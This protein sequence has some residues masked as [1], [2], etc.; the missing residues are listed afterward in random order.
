MNRMLDVPL[1]RIAALELFRSL[2]VDALSEVQAAMHVERVAKDAIICV[3]GDT[4][5]RA[6]ALGAGS[7]RIVQ[8]GN[9]GGQAIVR[10]IGQGEMFATVPLFT[11]HRSPADAIAVEPSTVLTWAEK[12]L[13]RLMADWPIISLNVIRAIGTRLIQVQERVRELTT[14]RAEQRIAH[15]LLRL[16]EQAG[17][18][19]S[20][21]TTIE[22]PLRRKDLAEYSGT[23]LHT[24]SRTIA[25]WEKTGI[26]A[27]H[28]LRLTIYDLGGI[29]R[30]A[31]RS[32]D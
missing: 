14:E 10:F 4:I 6:Y 11:D 32:A 19:G 8:T 18:D 1:D 9:N 29:R 31:D 13:L 3:Q 28:G 30:L 27:T 5:D 12:D 25:A 21:G 15:S 24:A 26:L 2:P 22:I 23:T 7:V 17:R 16:V 20:R